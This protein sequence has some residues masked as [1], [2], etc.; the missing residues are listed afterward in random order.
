[1]LDKMVLG[2]IIIKSL[3]ARSF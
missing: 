2:Y 3:S 1:M